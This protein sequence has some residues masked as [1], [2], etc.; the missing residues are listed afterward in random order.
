MGLPVVIAISLVV[1][2]IVFL[3]KLA[4]KGAEIPQLIIETNKDIRSTPNGV[5][6]D[7]SSL[8]SS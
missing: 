5:F 2:R 6:I 8:S 7:S 4:T 3:I 1:A